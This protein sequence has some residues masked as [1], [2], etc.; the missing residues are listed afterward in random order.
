MLL[1][2]IPQVVNHQ[3]TNS[4]ASDSYMKSLKDSIFCQASDEIDKL[5]LRTEQSLVDFK[6]DI[7]RKDVMNR[8]RLPAKKSMA[9][10]HYAVGLLTGLSIHPLVRVLTNASECKLTF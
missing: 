1:D 3:N 6:Q 2:L 4:Q 5:M 7:S 10:S 9:S 8:L